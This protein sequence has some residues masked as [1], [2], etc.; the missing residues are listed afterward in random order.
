MMIIINVSLTS[1]HFYC[2]FY[3]YTGFKTSNSLTSKTHLPL[4]SSF[5]SDSIVTPTPSVPHGK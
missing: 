3:V 4:S 2:H 1:Y 5:L